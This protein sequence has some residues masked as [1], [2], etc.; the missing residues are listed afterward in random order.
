M[1]IKLIQ[2]LLIAMLMG[3]FASTSRAADFDYTNDSEALATMNRLIDR[4][5]DG[6][7]LKIHFQAVILPLEQVNAFSVSDG[8]IIVTQGLLRTISSEEQL[9]AAIAHEMGH[10]ITEVKST[11][12]QAF[13]ATGD[14]E[15]T[16]DTLAIQVL[17]KARYN[18]TCLAE[19]LRVVL[20]SDGNSFPKA[21]VKQLSS[22]IRK[23]EDKVGSQISSVKT[24]A[25]HGA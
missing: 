10:Q 12:T 1:K 24:T 15:F 22:R 14:D 9:A 19:M 25:D 13:A 8:R 4:L 18:P 7:N 20:H 16:A 23:I 17:K 21:Q 2:I 6:S 11:K 5:T 3:G